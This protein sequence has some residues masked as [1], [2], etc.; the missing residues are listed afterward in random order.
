MAKAKTSTF[1]IRET[2]DVDATAQT[3]AMDLSLYVDPVNKQG[4]LVRSVDF[5]VTI[6]GGCTAVTCN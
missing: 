3:T 5:P 4:L 2:F 1:Y 6:H